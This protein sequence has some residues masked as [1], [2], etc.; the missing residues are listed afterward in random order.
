MRKYIQVLILSAALFSAPNVPGADKAPPGVDL[1]K[2][3]VVEEHKDYL[4]VLDAEGKRVKLSRNPKRAIIGFPSFVGLWYYSGGSAV[5]IPSSGNI[6]VI[7]KAA[8]H[9]PRLGSH[10]VLNLEKIIALQ[11]DLVVLYCVV[12]SHHDIQEI[13]RSAKV[14]T[15]L[16]EYRNYSDFVRILDLFARINNASEKSRELTSRITVPIDKMRAKASKLKSPKFVSCRLT[17][18]GVSAEANIAN[19]AHIAMLLGGRNI[20]SDEAVPAG[21]RMVKYSLEKMVMDDPEIILITTGHKNFPKLKKKLRNDPLWSSLSAVKSDRVYFLPNRLF[22]YRAN[23]R[24]PE[25]FKMVAEALYPDAK[26]E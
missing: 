23:E 4:V 18:H 21:A 24:Y 16:I 6:E 9:L 15:I 14:Q 19:T 2:S 7:P 11:P 8:R 26:W 13:M 25:A 5:G 12:K 20:V 17:T 10:S 3:C 1:N 22:L